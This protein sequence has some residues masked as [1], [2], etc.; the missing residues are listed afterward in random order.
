MGV[1]QSFPTLHDMTKRDIFEFGAIS[2]EK[3][4]DDACTREY[5]FPIRI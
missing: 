4:F 3:I 5:Y 2:V 1:A